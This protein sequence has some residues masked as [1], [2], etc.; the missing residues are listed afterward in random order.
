MESNRSNGNAPN[1]LT[2]DSNY[3]RHNN[4]SDG[5]RPDNNFSNNC[6][7]DNSDSNHSNRSLMIISNLVQVCIMLTTQ[8]PMRFMHLV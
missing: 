8:L 1:H 3:N 7:N 5:N 4:E 2:D 6:S